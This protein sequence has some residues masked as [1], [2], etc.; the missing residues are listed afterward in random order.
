MNGREADCGWTGRNGLLLVLVSMLWAGPG[1][2]VAEASGPGS[3]S[4]TGGGTKLSSG[5]CD[6]EID[7]DEVSA[8][9]GFATTSAL[10]ERYADLGVHFEGPEGNDGGAILNECAGFG[11]TGHSSPCLLGFNSSAELAGGAL[12]RGPETVRFDETIV[13]FAA[14]FGTGLSGTATLTAY[15]GENEVDEISAPVG[16]AIVRLQVMGKNITH[17]T[18]DCT[19]GLWAVDDICAIHEGGA[20]V[21][22]LRGICAS[23]SGFSHD[24]ASAALANLG[25][26]NAVLVSDVDDFEFAIRTGEWDLI[27]VDDQAATFPRPVM[28]ALWIYGDAGGRVLFS[29]GRLGVHAVHDFL[30]LAGVEYVGSYTEPLPVYAW[31]GPPLFDTP[32]QVPGLTVFAN[33]C[34]IDGHYLDPGSATAAAGYTPLPAPNQAAV[35]VNESE[36]VI[37]NG[38]SLGLSEQDSDADGKQ[39]AVELYENEIHYLAGVGDGALQVSP[40]ALAFSLPEGGRDTQSVTLSNP[41]P[42]PVT[43]S[44]GT[45][46]VLLVNTA[47]PGRFLGELRREP[48][49]IGVD[50]LDARYATPEAEDLLAYDAVV[51]ASEGAFHDREALGDALADYVNE[52]G[53]VI[54]TIDTFGFIEDSSLGGR[55]VEDGYMVFETPA[56]HVTGTRHLGDFEAG[57]PVMQDIDDIRSSFTERAALSYGAA[58][59]AE[60]DDGAPLA[61]SKGDGVVGFNIRISPDDLGYEGEVAH[62]FRNAV[63]WLCG[64]SPLTFH[65]AG[66]TLAPGAEATVEITADAAG[67]PVDTFRDLLVS[68]NGVGGGHAELTV[69]LVVTSSC[70]PGATFSQRPSMP[71][72]AV[73]N[74]FTSNTNAPSRCVDNFSGLQRPILAVYWWGCDAE[75]SGGW[76]ECD[77]PEPDKFRIIFYRDDGG[78]PGETVSIFNLEPNVRNTGLEGRGMFEIKEYRAI[79]P[80]PVDLETGWVSVIGAGSS[81]CLFRWIGSPEGDGRG[82]SIGSDSSVS[83]I[84][85]L[86]LCLVTDP[87]C[88]ALA[89][90]ACNTETAATTSGQPQAMNVYACAGWDA[91]GPEAVY[92]FTPVAG[93]EVSIY[94]SDAAADLDLYVLEETCRPERCIAFGDN[95]LS[96]TGEVGTTYFVVVDGYEGAAGA[97]VLHVECPAAEGESE[98]EG[99]GGV[100]PCET[101]TDPPELTL[102]GPVALTLNLCPGDPVPALPAATALDACEGDLTHSVVVGGDAVLTTPG[103]YTVTYNVSDAA[104]NAAPETKRMVT[105][106]AP[107]GDNLYLP[108]YGVLVECGDPYTPPQAHVRSSCAALG[109]AVSTTD[110]VDTQQPGAYTLNYTR[111]GTPPVALIVAVV[112][113]A[114]PVLTLNGDAAVTVDCGGTYEDPGATAADACAGDMTPA[115]EVDNP[116]DADVPGDYTVTYSVSDA[117]GNAAESLTRQVTVSDDCGCC[118]G[119]CGGCGGE[120]KGL[121]ELRRFLG[122]YLLV[123]IAFLVLAAVQMHRF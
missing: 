45:A 1:V 70:P 46:R 120:G 60:W 108:D 86:S 106:E 121:S 12:A 61:A 9:C 44:L 66:G 91:T 87:A 117:S 19:A 85:D 25:F 24:Y 67:L 69:S 34:N 94:L 51:V 98:G 53:K 15:S 52:G 42:V 62:L 76:S 80:S 116:V 13:F 4:E 109:E 103:V 11:I 59:I 105:V 2:V 89:D 27:V 93:G 3:V 111:E 33:Y 74:L 115:I 75:L 17:V 72:E 56:V 107:I 64:E 37:I 8:P 118:G 32:N 16:E 29:H 88:D 23:L 55:F 119:G 96:F 100:D 6:I 71:S 38:F 22:V 30:Y 14:S 122:D 97:F 113:S 58:V 90:L 99:E 50:Y 84:G 83:D 73:W 41:M 31:D 28:D 21:L 82:L 49:I 92:R 114:A 57:H 65:P 26:T 54:H 20:G 110:T 40:G 95:A 39:D 78:E 10:R 47:A 5:D 81:T 18:F 7:F 48:G 104:G 68:F 102:I 43:W 63:L 36:R 77:R 112:D 35:T 101:D 123:G 79:L